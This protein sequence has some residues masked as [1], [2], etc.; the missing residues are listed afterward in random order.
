MERVL[1]P[2]M[3][4][5]VRALQMSVVWFSSYRITD[6]QRSKPFHPFKAFS[7]VF[8]MDTGRCLNRR[9]DRVLSN[10]PSHSFTMDRALR[11]LLQ[12]F[13]AT[14]VA[15]QPHLR[16]HSLDPQ[17]A[18]YRLYRRQSQSLE[19]VQNGPPSSASNS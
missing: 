15:P 10:H 4:D 8:G 12:V 18:P 17:I 3:G 13:Y 2:Q 9:T 16:P 6:E 1:G 5:F 19:K 14:R 11:G 7:S